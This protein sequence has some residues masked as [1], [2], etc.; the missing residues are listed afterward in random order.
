MVDGSWED[1]QPAATNH[2]IETKVYVALAIFAGRKI[3]PGKDIS[4]LHR[5]ALGDVD[6]G[7][8][9]VWNEMAGGIAR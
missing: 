8:V 1:P 2:A 6:K 9:K 5:L 4:L 3:H 7:D